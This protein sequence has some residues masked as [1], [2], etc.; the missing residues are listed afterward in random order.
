MAL[1]EISQ[2]LKQAVQTFR[3]LSFASKIL[4][5]DKNLVMLI[6]MTKVCYDHSDYVII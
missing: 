2:D 1:I 5:L 6:V 3:K 4:R